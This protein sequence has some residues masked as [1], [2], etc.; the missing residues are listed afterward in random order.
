MSDE[1]PAG[2]TSIHLG[3][4]VSA[5]K[6]KKPGAVKP[7]PSNGFVPYLDIQA[8]EKGNIRSYAQAATSRL[9]TTD[10]VLVVWD[11]AR[12]GWVGLGRE[13]AIGSTIMALQP[14][15]GERTYLYRWLQSQFQHVNTNTRGTGIPH[16]DPEVLWSLEV[17]LAPLA[18]QRRIIAK[19]ETLLGKVDACQQR[20]AKI[21]LLLK[22][23]RQ[24][25]L[26]A[27]CSGRLTADWREERAADGT[28][29]TDGNGEFPRTWTFVRFGELISDGPQN[30]L[31]KPASFYGGGTLIVRIDTFYDGTIAAWSELKRV[32]LTQKE[33]NQFVLRNGDIVINR[34]N[35]L[36]FLGKAALVRKLKEACVYESNMM[37]LRLDTT[38]ALPDYAILYLQSPP[39]VAELRK[40]AKHAVNQSSIN[41]EDVKAATFN[42]PPLAEQQEIV[43]RVE[44][45]FT[46]ADQIEVRFQ[47]AQEQVDK[48]TPS[49]LAR[50]FCGKLVPQDPADERAERLLE[51]IKSGKQE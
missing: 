51:R 36:K 43:R 34:V 2:W 10:D 22:R 26:A 12:S 21:P 32:R 30:G 19:L 15:V 41:Q 7:V 24:S 37:R 28:D 23:F 1:L 29:H 42:L 33:R 13:G 6:G 3:G 38:R 40:N 25:V 27:A 17:P 11:G 45:L 9:G 20:L 35:S 4:L 18:E 44:A 5:R 47:K 14:K 8:I 46:L 50:A 48:L 49:L 31:Y 39:G 16:V